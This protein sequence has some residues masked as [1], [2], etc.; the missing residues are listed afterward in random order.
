MKLVLIPVGATEWHAEGRLLGRVELP[1]TP[2]GQQTCTAWAEQL[3]AAG[4]QRIVHATDELATHTAKL[5]ARALSVP[6]KAADE[7]IEVD[8]GLWAGLTPAELKARFAS[9]HRELRE[10]PLHVIPPGGEAL[11]DT[12]ERLTAGLRKLLR[13]DGKKVVGVVLRPFSLVLVRWAFEHSEPAD[14]LEAQHAATEPVL[15][16]CELT[17]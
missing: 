17:A 7:L 8:L 2:E 12:S 4:V 13:R 10:A 3:R 5:L 15:L 6:T 14:M 16:E 11:A 9:A 1:L